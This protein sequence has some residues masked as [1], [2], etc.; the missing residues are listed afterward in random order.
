MKKYLYDQKGVLIDTVEKKTF[1]DG[2]EYLG[3]ILNNQR[4]GKGIYNYSNGDNYFGE[5]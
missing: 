1:E 5:W 3:Y 4:E 2:S